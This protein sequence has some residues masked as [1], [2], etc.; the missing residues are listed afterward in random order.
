MLI[1]SKSKARQVSNQYGVEV[2]RDQAESNAI[3]CLLNCYLRE[4]AIVRK[5]VNFNDNQPDCPLSL[6]QRLTQGQ[7]KIRIKLPESA[8]ILLLVADR[9]SLLGRVRFSSQLYVKK[10]ASVW[11]LYSAEQLIKLLLQHLSKLTNTAFNDELLAQ[12]DNSIAVTQA[13]LQRL[14]SKV[15]SGSSMG[16]D[17]AAMSLINSEQ[18]LIWGHA[19]HPSPKSRHGVSF[20]DMLACS[21]EIK[22][23]FPL[24]WFKV[25]PSLI[26]QMHCTAVQ[27]MDWINK[28]KPD[29]ANLYPCHPWEVKTI[30]AQPLVQQAIALGLIE[31]MGQMGS[32]IYPTSSVRTTYSADINQFIKFSIHV[33]LTNCVRKNAWYELESAVALSRVLMA[34]AS[35]VQQH[36]P[37]FS[38]MAEPAASTLDLSRLEGEQS[39][40][41]SQSQMVSECF[42]ILYREGIP[43]AQLELYQ[44]EVAG[45]LF[46][47]DHQGNS[48]CEARLRAIA[49]RRQQ[50]YQQTASQWFAA[51]VQLLLP[52]VFHFFFKRGVAFEPHLQNTVIGFENDLPA[53]IWLRDLEGTKLLPEFWPQ[54]L[55]SELSEEA[56]NSVYYS[57]EQ[58][59]NR[60]AYCSLINNVSEAMFH[61]AA[62]DQVLETELW[63][64]AARVVEQWQQV[65]GQQPELAGFLQGESI[66]SKNNLSTRLFKKSDRLSSYT[67]LANPLSDLQD[68]RGFKNNQPLATYT[69]LVSDVDALG[70]L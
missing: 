43:L 6:S 4:F 63:L 33:R 20:D 53:Y 9:V 12:I 15:F 49:K 39:S 68:Q 35:D 58:G 51:Y 48:V 2:Y 46:G 24:Y 11:Q 64:I 50:S 60:V 47:W 17:S 1:Q 69:P 42:G 41:S 21:P 28:L 36:Y 61:L 26:R 16:S 59:W 18:S 30:L 55:L 32:D 7:Q 56:M 34:V 27:P 23:N 19:M 62:G 25:D 67:Q 38:L 44:P 57:R 8:A 52:A 54:Q 37:H 22:A 70:S 10:S 31:P 5:Q 65:E 40:A 14:D 29:N 45:A 13:F 3:G 66:P